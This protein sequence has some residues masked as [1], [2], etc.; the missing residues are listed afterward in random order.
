LDEVDKL[1]KEVEERRKAVEEKE[2]RL[3]DIESPER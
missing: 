3:A 1:E 2:A